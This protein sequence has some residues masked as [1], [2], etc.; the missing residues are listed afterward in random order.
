MW[1]L[2]ALVMA[3]IN[4]F[5]ILFS[6]ST[7]GGDLQ[8]RYLRYLTQVEAYVNLAA[9]PWPPFAGDEDYPVDLEVTEQRRQNRWKTAF[10]A[11]LALPATTLASA[12]GGAAVQFG[13][14]NARFSMG[15]IVTG[16]FLGWFA[17]L[18]RGTMPQGLRDLVSYGIGYSMQAAGYFLLV[19]DRYPNSDPLAVSYPAA[20]PAHV[21]TIESTD[22]L[23]RS[24]LTVFFRLLLFLPHLVWFLLW[25]VAA[26]IATIANWFVTLFRGVPAAPL[27]RFLSA[28]VRYSTHIT[29]YAYL[30]SN[31]FPGFTGA[32]GS[33]PV[34]LQI[35]PPERQ[36]RW[37]TGFRLVLAVPAYFVAGALGNALLLVGIYG[38]FV[39]LI[40]GRMPAGL[41]RLGVFALRYSAQLYAYTA[42]L[43]DRYPFSGPSQEAVVSA[44]AAPATT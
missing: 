27:C 9:D 7:V 37:K 29:A 44:P 39:G 17:I 6:G 15:I 30:V 25:S 18:A 1:S 11:V 26:L 31:P 34:D 35:A 20:A 36:N 41:Q 38:W 32:P 5:A 8:T 43:T 33:Y 13:A 40:R 23:E 2:V 16:A 3:M 24:R 4:W 19:T 42:L 12:F 28:F 22:D 21:V 10:R 14:G